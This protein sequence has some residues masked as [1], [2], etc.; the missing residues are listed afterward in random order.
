MKRI[1]GICIGAFYAVLTWLAMTTANQNWW[2]GNLDLGLWWAVIGALFGIAG[3][4]ALWGTWFH[5]RP[6]ED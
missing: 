2:V 6:S 1:I 5:T 4:S 3:L